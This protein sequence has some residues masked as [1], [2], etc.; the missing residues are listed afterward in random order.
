MDKLTKQNAKLLEDSKSLGKNMEVLKKEIHGLSQKCRGQQT[1]LLV[2]WSEESAMVLVDGLKSEIK[3]LEARLHLQPITV[4]DLLNLGE[5]APPASSVEMT[6]IWEREVLYL[7]T[8]LSYMEYISMERWKRAWD[9]AVALGKENVLVE[10]VVRGDLS[11]ENYG[12]AYSYIGDFGCS[13]LMGCGA[14]EKASAQRR[15]NQARCY[16]GARQTLVPM[17][18]D[19]QLQAEIGSWILEHFKR[20]KT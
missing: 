5:K 15:S 4:G 2:E 7:M 8:G 13:F 1:T 14:M 12:D 9:D 6:Y 18:M 17:D 10:V 11:L 20:W 19:R 3:Q 16:E